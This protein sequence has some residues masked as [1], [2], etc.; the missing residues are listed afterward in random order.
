MKTISLKNQETLFR[1]PYFFASI[2]IL[3]WATVATA[4]TIALKHL[5]IPMLLNI[6]SLTSASTMFVFLVAENKL[7]LLKKI[8]RKDVKK[9]FAL[10]FFNPL[11]YYIMLFKGYSLLPA[12]EAQPISYTWPIILTILSAIFLKEKLSFRKCLGIAISF[13]GVLF[14][15][16]KGNILNFEFSS[17][18][19]VIITL[20]SSLI[21][22]SYWL[23][24]SRDTRDEVVKNFLNFSIVGVVLTIY[25][26]VFPETVSL[27]A[28]G[29]NAAI[30]VGLSE[31]GIAFLFWGK[32]MS[33]AKTKA[34]ISKLVYLIPF[35]SLIVLHF[36]LG[37]A[38][39]PSTL[40]GL[41]F[42]IGGLL[43]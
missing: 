40:I 15:S 37:V 1:N 42:I 36:T 22:A 34:S 33:L 23:V 25:H 7:H 27:S 9:S 13:F 41:A 4:F 14:I 17:P 29:L 2:S 39:L 24:S 6:A 31:M 11:C 3:L 16:T 32:A 5:S 19:G 21:W 18:M 20:F 43:F 28:K 30:Y 8:T 12:Q 38:I 10:A 35:L 26:L